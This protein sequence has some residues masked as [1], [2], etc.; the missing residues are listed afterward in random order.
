MR[1]RNIVIGLLAIIGAGVATGVIAPE[2]VV[3]RRS[4]STLRQGPVT[5]VGD[6]L[7][8]GIEPYLGEELDGWALTADD[9]VG[10]STATGL[11]HLRDRAATLGS[12]VVVSLGTNDRLD[13][14]DAFRASVD[15]ALRVASGRCVV[16]ATIHRDGDAYEP[17]NAVLRDAAARNRSLRLVEWTAMVR[18][19]PEWL[20]ADGIHAGEDGYRARARA[21]VDA[22]RTCP[23][24]T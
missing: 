17:F 2:V 24:Q 23:A 7:N 22:M 9:V 19:H 5:L 3:H 16:W 21:V 6:S 12:Y 11:E 1:R 15:E 20:A 10:R 18:D 13:Q 8:V 4:H 14:L